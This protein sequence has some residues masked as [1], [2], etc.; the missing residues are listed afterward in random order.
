MRHLTEKKMFFVL[1]VAVF[2]F[3]ALLS[4]CR[5]SS[6]VTFYTLNTQTPVFNKQETPSKIERSPSIGI[7]PIQLPEYLDRPQI[8]TLNGAHTLHLA[9]F[10]RWAAPLDQ[11]IVQVLAKNLIALLPASK[12]ALFPWEV[13]QNPQYLVE[14]TFYHFEGVL[15]ESFHAQGIWM[16]AEKEGGS[17]ENYRK[18]DLRIPVSGERYEDLAEACSKSLWMLSTEISSAVNKK[19]V[20]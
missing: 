16:L 1:W 20:K 17:G 4:S 6:P 9:E 14:L 3:I 7:N 8:V 19:N 15:G 11:E 18:F 2:G 10:H 5:S 12:V 13:S